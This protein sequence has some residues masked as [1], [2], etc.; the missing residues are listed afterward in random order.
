MYSDAIS[1]EL[2]KLGLDVI[3]IHDR[4]HLEGSFP[5]TRAG[6]GLLVRSLVGF[7][8]G[9]KEDDLV[10]GCQYLERD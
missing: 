6:I 9:T 8:A 7:A 10:D 1:S 2:R 5:R 3:S 4:P